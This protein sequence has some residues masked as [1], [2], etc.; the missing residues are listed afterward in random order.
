MR[1]RHRGPLQAHRVSGAPGGANRAAQGQRLERV[2]LSLQGNLGAVEGA[3]MDWE[4]AKERVAREVA[5]RYSNVDADGE[6]VGADGR[7]PTGLMADGD[8]TSGRPD[9]GKIYSGAAIIGSG[10]WQYDGNPNQR[11]EWR[12]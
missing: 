6:A 7:A 12:R 1:E 4:A 9:C 10:L 8:A 2:A 5:R 3:P 11:C